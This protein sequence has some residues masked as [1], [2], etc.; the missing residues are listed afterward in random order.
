MCV[1]E[2]D[3]TS[4]ARSLT[5][6]S[7]AASRPGALLSGSAQIAGTLSVLRMG[8]GPE[9]SAAARRAAAAAA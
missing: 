5:E 2:F 1:P 7:A 8:G 6:F 9:P 4:Q 3:A